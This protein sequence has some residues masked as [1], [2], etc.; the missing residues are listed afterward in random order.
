[1]LP[2]RPLMVPPV[3]SSVPFTVSVPAPVSVPLP[4]NSTFVA[5]TFAAASIAIVPPEAIRV[6]PAPG[7]A[8]AALQGQCAPIDLHL[9]T[10]QGADLSRAAGPRASAGKI[11]IQR[12]CLGFQKA[13]VHERNA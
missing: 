1:M 4:S 5:A 8:G 11:E 12:A 6:W 3:H 9:G 7:Q 13:A 2:L 10:R